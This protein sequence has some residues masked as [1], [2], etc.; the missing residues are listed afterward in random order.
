MV[1][2][3]GIC[4]DLIMLVSSGKLLIM[5]FFVVVSCDSFIYF[6]N[7]EELQHG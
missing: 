6:L 1:E 2:G 5:V 7:S 4:L 3:G